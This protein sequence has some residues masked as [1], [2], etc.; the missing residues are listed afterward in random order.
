MKGFEWRLSVSCH[1]FAVE[2][3]AGYQGVY[4][5]LALSQW[6]RNFLTGC[7][8]KSYGVSGCCCHSSLDGYEGTTCL[9]FAHVLTQG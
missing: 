4:A 8:E 6:V 3:V 1:N 5:L 2:V 9:R 7:E